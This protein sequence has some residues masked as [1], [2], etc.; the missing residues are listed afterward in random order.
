M[1]Q[2]KSI[3]PRL[4]QQNQAAFRG[5]LDLVRGYW[6][7]T[8]GPLIAKHSVPVRLRAGRLVVEAE[9]PPW[10]E[11]LMPMRRQIVNVLRSEL[12]GTKV[13]AIEV[14]LPGEDRHEGRRER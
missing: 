13:R 1:E 10:R 9:G 6:A 8:V 3:L 11:L 4:F 2:A 12:P 14:R 7:E 5:E